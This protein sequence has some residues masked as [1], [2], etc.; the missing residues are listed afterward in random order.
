M[1]EDMSNQQKS[2]MLAQLV[3]WSFEVITPRDI[4]EPPF[5]ILRDENGND[6]WWK[7][8]VYHDSPPAPPNLYD[9]ANMALLAHV[10]GW[11][12]GVTNWKPHIKMWVKWMMYARDEMLILHLHEWMCNCADYGLELAIEAGMVKE[13]EER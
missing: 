13:P 2:V 6:L 5:A 10:M 12:A 4:H 1:A 7:N 11:F 8:F 3:E 9:S